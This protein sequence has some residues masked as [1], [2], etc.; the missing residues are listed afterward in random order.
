M[1]KHSDAN[2]KK[3]YARIIVDTLFLLLL[4][5]QKVVGALSH[6]YSFF[7]YGKK[8]MFFDDSQRIALP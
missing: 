5:E 3:V 7:K 6:L 4:R 8:L 2:A 1:Q